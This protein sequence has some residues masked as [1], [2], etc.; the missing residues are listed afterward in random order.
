MWS[1]CR[2]G[3]GGVAVLM[4][5]AMADPAAA[6]PQGA[7]LAGRV[8]DD[9]TGSGI[10]GARVELLSDDRRVLHTTAAGDSGNFSIPIRRRGH[11]RLRASRIG[12]AEVVTPAV[13]VTLADSLEVEVRLSTGRVLL[14]PLQVVARP[15]RRHRSHGLD[16]FRTRLGAQMGGRFITREQVARRNTSRLTD[17]LAINGLV[18]AGTGLYFPRNRC[19]P[20]V[21]MD[22]MLV[23]RPLP[24]RRGRIIG[25]EAYDAVNMVSPGDVEGIEIYQGRSSIPAEFGGPG[26]EC[27]VIAIWTRRSEP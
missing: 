6:Q 9:S 15:A 17:I 8:L 25:S 2:S 27:G 3:V 23:T 20:M 1:T 21:Y 12:F 19:S 7:F 10:V 13:R 5:L 18:V 11:Y 26:A 14:A 22:G 4:L 24:V 16:N